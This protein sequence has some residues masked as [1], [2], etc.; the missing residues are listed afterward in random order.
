MLARARGPAAPPRLAAILSA[1]IVL[2]LALVGRPGSIASADPPASAA[3]PVL[4]EPTDFALE[5]TSGVT[6]TMREV[7]GRVVLVFYEDREHARDNMNLKLRLQ[8]FVIDNALSDETRTYAIANVAGVDG[9]SRD[10]AR[11]AIR[12]IASHHGLQLLLDWEGAMQRA[13]FDFAG[14]APTVALFD[15]EGRLRHRASGTLTASDESEVFRVL[16]R[17]L[18]ER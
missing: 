17:L 14:E 5:E 6:R 18:R 10:L 2:A 4:S 3:V 7:R 1:G 12:A 11:V 9:I 8:R 16:R 15:R 13:P